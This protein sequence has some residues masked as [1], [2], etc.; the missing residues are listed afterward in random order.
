MS[1]C[2]D[3]KAE[4]CA[5]EDYGRG[6]RAGLRKQTGIAL[7]SWP[8]DRV[9]NLILQISHCKST[10]NRDSAAMRLCFGSRHEA[11]MQT[12]NCT[13]PVTASDAAALGP[14]L[15]KTSARDWFS[16]TLHS[17]RTQD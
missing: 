3:F 12:C 4:L 14:K 6:V 9:A 15:H 16:C 2:G 17:L 8:D 11:H 1:L 10:C 13:A 5:D 7:Q